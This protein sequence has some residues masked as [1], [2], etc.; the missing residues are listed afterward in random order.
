MIIYYNSKNIYML[1]IIN[2]QNLLLFFLV[3]SGN[4]ICIIFIATII[5]YLSYCNK[6]TNGFII[7]LYLYNN[8]CFFINIDKL[9]N[10]NKYLRNLIS[11]N[12][13]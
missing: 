2:Y 12:N 13:L 4:I 6:V 1:F 9:R 3:Y 11:I 10:H 5:Y 8:T 7:K